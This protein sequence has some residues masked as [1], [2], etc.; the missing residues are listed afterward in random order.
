MRKVRYRLNI[1]KLDRLSEAERRSLLPVTKRYK[2]RANDYYL[3]LI[4]WDD[5]DDPIRRIVIPRP[6]ELDDFGR[7]DASNEQDNYAAPGCQHKY[8]DTALLLCNE[9]CGAYCRFCFRKR[10]FQDENHEVVFDVTPGI[11]YIRRTPAIT[12][13]LLTGGDPLMLSTEQIENILRP[14]REIEHVRIIRIG[15][16][17]PAFNPYRIIDDPALL[18][19]LSRYSTR[20]QRVYVMAHFNHPRE[21]T[22]ESRLALDLLMKAGVTTVNQSPVIGGLNDDPAVLADLMRELSFIGVPPY[23][24]FQ[25]R[26][27]EGNKPFDIPIVRTW[28]V[29]EQARRAVSGLAR[30][31]R[32]V[33]SHDLGKIEILACTDKHIYLKF[34]RARYPDDEGRLLVC[35]RDDRAYWLDDLTMADGAEHPCRRRPPRAALSQDSVTLQRS[36]Q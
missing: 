33:M 22:D 11:D 28:E 16:K 30:R 9:V 17:M 15:S 36:A 14:L 3:G 6:D 7:L 18:A 19:V 31:A 35:H 10:L 5:P 1:K 13:V 2:F 4:N 26:P 12:N 8:T 29:F 32:L 24:F 34:H 27:T 21:L 25:C 23:Y 20:E